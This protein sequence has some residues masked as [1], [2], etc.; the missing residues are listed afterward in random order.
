MW[1]CGE[2]G[3]PIRIWIDILLSK[4][5]VVARCTASPLYFHES[6]D[7]QPPLMPCMQ[8]DHLARHNVHGRSVMTFLARVRPVR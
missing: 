4:L 2:F 3:A 5:G 7:R 1:E 8:D 6:L